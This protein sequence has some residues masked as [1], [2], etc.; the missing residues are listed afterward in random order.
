M[1]SSSES[2]SPQPRRRGLARL[3]W[4]AAVL[5]VLLYAFRAFVADV[6]PVDS[7][8]MEPA[9]F[10]GDHVLVR[11]DESVPARGE[12]VVVE[13]QD[14]QPLVKR[15]GGLPG[16]RVLVA[17]D[18]DLLVETDREGLA[19]G[20]LDRPG[21]PLVPV[22]DDTV[23]DVETHFAHGSTGEDPWSVREQAW[24]L[25]ARA[26]DPGSHAGFLRHH[27]GIH[28]DRVLPD[29]T[30]VVG[31]TSVGDACV[32]CEVQPLVAGGEIALQ[33]VERGDTFTARLDLTDPNQ[34][35]ATLER[36]A[37][38]GPGDAVPD[39][40]LA[41]AVTRVPL[42]AWTQLRFLNVDNHLRLEVDGVAL[43]DHR[44]AANRQ[45]PGPGGI[46]TGERVTLGGVG[47]HVRF[48][49]I[50]VHR[51][52]H[53]TQRGSIGVTAPV[54]LGPNEVYL[55]G[56][57]SSLSTDSREFGP[58]SL[59]RLVGRVTRIVWPR[60]RARALGPGR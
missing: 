5:V 29:G 15:V 25:D 14:G 11:Y 1:A 33:L 7:S 8:S 37:A 20:G 44:Y 47:C 23:Q 18:G 50:R 3:I 22:F 49:A 56:D 55:L 19:R 51:D 43:L 60:A 39:G 30:V 13:G 40:E 31:R 9:L 16:E 58:V 48:R 27:P 17:L 24:E 57:N 53:Y 52:V 54:T 32:A 41:R 59:D 6:Y 4:T 42:G 46:S 34:V 12:L 45:G 36:L 21:P 2:A 26:L 38:F 10:P 35:T 28:D